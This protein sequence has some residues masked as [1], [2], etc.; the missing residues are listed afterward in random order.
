MN[1]A[2]KTRNF[3][4]IFYLKE[5]FNF[6]FIYQGDVT[7]LCLNKGQEYVSTEYVEKVKWNHYMPLGSGGWAIPLHKQIADDL[8]NVLFTNSTITF[9]VLKTVGDEDGE[10]I[11]KITY[12]TQF[13]G[14]T[15]SNEI[16]LH[17]AEAEGD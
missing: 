1:I 2:L 17:Q 5:T 8:E 4:K 12:F 15:V 3:T 9:I 16:Y 10:V 7:F 11:N 6:T 13:G 14:E